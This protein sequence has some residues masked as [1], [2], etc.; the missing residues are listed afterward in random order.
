M[1]KWYRNTRILIV[2]MAA[3][4]PFLPS[5]IQAETSYTLVDDYRLYTYSEYRAARQH[6]TILQIKVIDER[7]GKHE[8]ASQRK[9]L[10]ET[11]E[12]FWMEPVSEMLERILMRE[13][14]LS[15]LFRKVERADT[16]DGLI[17]ELA[18][19]TFQGQAKRVGVLGRMIEADIAFS[20]KLSRRNRPK[21]LFTKDYH[22]QATVT[23][24]SILKSG[25]RTMVEQIGKALEEIVPVL[26]SD[27]ERVLEK[28]RPP[29]KARRS[30]KKK[31]KPIHLEPVGPK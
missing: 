15:F 4:G 5:E 17:L 20:A 16:R 22:S 11:D 27:I 12:T 28:T 19:R 1:I 9:P 10:L 23:L 6:N 24:K 13:F 3:A 21:N 2:F 29:M 7:K 18:F 30:T 31:A 8:H 26:M 14:A 25:R